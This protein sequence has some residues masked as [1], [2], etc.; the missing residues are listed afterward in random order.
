[1]PVEHSPSKNNSP[2]KEDRASQDG[3]LAIHTPSSSGTASEKPQNTMSE[4][5]IQAAQLKD[6]KI[7]TFWKARPKL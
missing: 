6:I 2:S 5:Q 4:I 7:A 1:M 3:A